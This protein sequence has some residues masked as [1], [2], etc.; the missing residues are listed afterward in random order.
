[1]CGAAAQGSDCLCQSRGACCGAA[2]QGQWPPLSTLRVSLG[3]AP[4]TQ[5]YRDRARGR[6]GAAPHDGVVRVWRGVR[7]M[8]GW[9]LH[10]DSCEC[11]SACC[12]MTVTTDAPSR[13]VTILC[14]ES[15][16]SSPD[17]VTTV[18]IDAPS[19]AVQYYVSRPNRVLRIRKSCHTSEL[20]GFGIV[21]SCVLAWS[22]TAQVETA[23]HVL[24]R[25]PCQHSKMRV[26]HFP[27]AKAWEFMSTPAPVD[28]LK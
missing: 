10:S 22:G 5:R 7:C 18:T 14:F 8:I 16:K 26:N 21:F 17:L 28:P 13:A 9:R 1:M 24:T 15:K 27:H 2:A 4:P 3:D 19:W 20:S 23:H 12:K 6:Q 25:A 11:E